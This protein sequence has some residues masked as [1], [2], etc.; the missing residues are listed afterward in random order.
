MDWKISEGAAAM[1]ASPRTWKGPGGWARR[2]LFP[3]D[4]P[5]GAFAWIEDPE[6]K[7]VGLWKAKS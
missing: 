6:G 7:T 4:I 2:H 3:L 1:I 5:T